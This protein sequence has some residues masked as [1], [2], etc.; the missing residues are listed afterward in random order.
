MR[1]AAATALP[2][3]CVT[4]T[5]DGLTHLVV[6]SPALPSTDPDRLPMTSLCAQRTDQER[7]D[8]PSTVQCLLCL[9]RVP[10]FIGLPAY[11]VLP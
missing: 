4:T 10:Q 11:E 5:G 6:T 2:F 7:P 1:M 8:H 3:R 9:H